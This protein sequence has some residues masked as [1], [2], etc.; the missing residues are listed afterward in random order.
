[1]Y[2]NV[3]TR[4]KTIKVMASTICVFLR[5]AQ[6]DHKRGRGSEPGLRE[7]RKR[8][9]LSEMLILPWR[10]RRRPARYRTP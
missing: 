4:T 3:A 10:Q 8:R 7:N 1:M 6:Q 2:E 9:F 5:I